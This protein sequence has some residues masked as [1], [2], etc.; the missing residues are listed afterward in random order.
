MN[1]PLEDLENT[2][3][4]LPAAVAGVRLG[5]RANRLLE[6]FSDAGRQDRRL[7]ALAEFAVV[8]DGRSDPHINSQVQR[9]LATASEA[10]EVM[11]DVRDETTLEDAADEYRNYIQSLATFEVS[12][13]SL[14]TQVIQRQFRPLGSVGSLLQAFPGARGLG[15]K[16][17]QAA[18]EAERHHQSAVVE[19]LPKAKA[20]LKQREALVQEQQVVAGNPKVA[21]FLQALADNRATLDLLEP[22]VLEW[23]GG[24]GAL[25]SLKVTA[26]H[27][28]KNL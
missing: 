8:L 15:E 4:L 21:A 24:Q 17:A 7:K 11:G 25:T 2:A 10:S 23:L 1:D 6:R 27:E 28:A 3:K 26:A 22:E 20:L 9:V 18:A 19:L 16:M 14:W 12:L 5:D 13:K